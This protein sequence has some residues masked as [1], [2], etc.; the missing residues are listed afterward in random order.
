MIRVVHVVGSLAGGGAE[1]L[2]LDLCRCSPSGL[3]QEVQPLV[4]GGAIEPEFRDAGVRLL[5]PVARGG[6]MGPG[7]LARLISRVKRF[8]VVHTHLWAG[9]AW[10]RLAGLGASRPVVSTEHNTRGD[11]RWRAAIARSM[12]PLSSQFIAVSESASVGL[13]AER[14]QVIANGID[15]VDHRP[16]P[17]PSP[18]EKRVLFIGRLERQ[19]GADVLLSALERLPDVRADLLG[20]GRERSALMRQAASLGGRARL[21]GWLADPGPLLDVC[22]VVVMPS[23]WEGFGLVA[24]EAM[25][26]GRVVVASAVDALPHVLG[27][28]GVMVPPDDPMELAKTLDG[29][30]SDPDALL[31]RSRR[32]PQQAAAFDIHKTAEATAALYRQVVMGRNRS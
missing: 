5:S 29:L 18:L 31:A 2:I 6:R 19:K 17:W 9:D 28:V 1:R 4:G 12:A 20:E 14:V 30:F 3:H 21:H 23:R 10:G 15:L 24:V 27:D 8:D 11:S 22:P 32:G 7:G 25:A 16:R 26:A 13:P